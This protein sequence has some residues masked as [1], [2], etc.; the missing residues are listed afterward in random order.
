MWGILTVTS[1]KCESHRVAGS[2]MDLVGRKGEE[3]VCP[4]RDGPVGG[5][6]GGRKHASKSGKVDELHDV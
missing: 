6:N 5:Q 4:D 1:H 2:R 3:I